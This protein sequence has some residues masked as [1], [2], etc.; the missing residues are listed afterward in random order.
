MKKIIILTGLIAFAL[1]IVLARM[2][3]PQS[4]PGVETSPDGY[5]KINIQAIESMA[6]ISCQAGF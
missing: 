2:Y 6:V 3:M 5:T 4:N 1:G